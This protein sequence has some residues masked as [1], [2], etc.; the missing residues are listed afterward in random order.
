MNV[1]PQRTRA[2]ECD[3]T[4]RRAEGGRLHAETGP[5]GAAARSNELR[6]GWP[7]ILACFAMAI[8]GW[9][10]G[11]YGQAIYLADLHVSRGWAVSELSLALTIYFVSGSLF[12][13]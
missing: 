4:P 7:A 1:E 3:A 5:T 8:F 13:T 12:L 2:V 9:G 6:D 10:F 11:F